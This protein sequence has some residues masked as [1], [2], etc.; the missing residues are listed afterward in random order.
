MDPLPS[1]CSFGS[2]VSCV[3]LEASSPDVN[4]SLVLDKIVSK[5]EARNANFSTVIEHYTSK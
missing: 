3:Y 2:F 4:F 5:L 1:R